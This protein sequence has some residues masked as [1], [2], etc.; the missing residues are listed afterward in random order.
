MGDQCMGGCWHHLLRFQDCGANRAVAAFRQA[1]LGAGGRNRRV[2][3]GGMTGGFD[4][5]GFCL[6][7]KRLILES[8][9]SVSQNTLAGTG[10]RSCNGGGCVDRFAFLCAAFSA[11]ALRCDLEG[12]CCP[13]VGR[14]VPGMP[15]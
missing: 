13:G 12:I 5:C 11:D 15:V 10:G 8:G 1:G 4:G 3:Y 6:N 2:D 7:L 14:G 9:G